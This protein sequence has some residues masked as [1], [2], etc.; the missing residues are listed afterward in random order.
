VKLTVLAVGKLRDAWL[1]EGAADYHKRVKA[2][3]PIEV[4]EARDDADLVKR[5]PRGRGAVWAL[6]ERGKQLS[7]EELAQTLKRAMDTGEAGITFV[8]GA[9]DGLPAQVLEQASFRWSLG[10]LTLPHRL[11]RV[12][13]L[14]QLY[15]AL[16]IIRGEPYHRP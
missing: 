5:L 6:D 13:L 4:I 7:S 15:R 9:A 3:L 12:I 8:I 16:S 1:E 10:R 14:E 11:V 2:R